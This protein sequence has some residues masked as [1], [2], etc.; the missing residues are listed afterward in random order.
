M[1]IESY[2][3]LKADIAAHEAKC[4]GDNAKRAAAAAE[5]KTSKDR[6]DDVL[7]R[8]AQGVYTDEIAIEVS[9]AQGEILIAE[10]RQQ[11]LLAELGVVNSLQGFAGATLR[12]KSEIEQQISDGTIL[13]E[14]QPALDELAE[15]Q[16]EY[17][18]KLRD[19]LHG[20]AIINR[21]LRNIQQ[22][23]QILEQQITGNR[24]DFGIMGTSQLGL[25]ALRKWVWLWMFDDLGEVTRRLENEAHEAANGPGYKGEGVIIRDKIVLPG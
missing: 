6:Y 16:A 2:E 21:K 7:N 25:D 8:A 14:M 10:K 18:D 9:K 20:R 23:T 15:I 19:V 13:A 5:V 4:Q 17:L 12:V 22:E 24:F 1:S 11:Q 3:K